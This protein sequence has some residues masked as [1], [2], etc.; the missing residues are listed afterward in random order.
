MT[1]CRVLS[2]VRTTDKI[3]KEKT[4]DGK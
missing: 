2:V 4:N 1:S 3:V